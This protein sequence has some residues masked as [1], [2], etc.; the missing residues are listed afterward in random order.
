MISSFHPFPWFCQDHQ[1][2]ELILYY[3]NNNTSRDY[4][5][6]ILKDPKACFP[7]L[8]IEDLHRDQFKTYHYMH[9]LSVR[10]STAL[11]KFLL[12][13]VVGIKSGWPWN[14]IEV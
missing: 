3:S 11:S 10:R 6:D 9:Y 2:Q 5:P 1:S 7:I 8:P 12:N 14:R 13:S 4:V